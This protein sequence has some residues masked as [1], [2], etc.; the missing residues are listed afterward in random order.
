MFGR[1]GCLFVPGNGSRDVLCDT[2]ALG[3]HVGDVDHGAD[4]PCVGRLLVVLE[5][6]WERLVEAALSQVVHGGQ[7]VCCPREPCISCSLE[8]VGGAWV[9][10]VFDGRVEVA[11]QGKG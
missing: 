7:V 3:K 1:G 4:K 8:E 6:L 5:S 2:C 10:V 11:G 9:C